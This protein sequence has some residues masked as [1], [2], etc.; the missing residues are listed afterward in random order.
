LA[1]FI[2]VAWYAKAASQK[3]AQ[4][5]DLDHLEPEINMDNDF[6]DYFEQELK[7][8]SIGDID[9]EP[10]VSL[11]SAAETI[12]SELEPV[13]KLEADNIKQSDEP[14]VKQPAKS[15]LNIVI[16][17][18]D[19]DSID[20][21]IP[22]QRQ[23][24]S[25]PDSSS[26]PLQQVEE[27]D[28]GEE[29]VPVSVQSQTKSPSKDGDDMVIALT[30]MAGDTTRFS[31]KAVKAG[32]DSSNLQFGDLQV[33]HRFTT[34]LRN[35]QS[36]FSVANILDPG[37]L[38]PDE[39]ISLTTPGLLIFARLP[40]PV[41]GLIVFDDLLETAQSLTEKLGGTLCDDARQPISDSRL[42]SMRSRIFNL[43]FALHNENNDYI[44]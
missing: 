38:L 27:L 31:G 5:L 29:V 22:Y 12:L 39:L 30:I 44:N 37:T 42:E 20:Q 17:G 16:D 13:I 40:G 43:N 3:R 41:N 26:A 9:S 14:A 28:L 4:D 15:S 33:Y 25:E 7:Q 24:R 1:V 19:M 2:A 34:G 36:I 32:L 6:N 35:R 18:D 23:A 10:A 21:A 8:Q 11:S